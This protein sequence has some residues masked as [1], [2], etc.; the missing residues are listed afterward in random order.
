MAHPVVPGLY[1]RPAAFFWPKIST[2]VR[3]LK[4]RA[5]L[6]TLRGRFRLLRWISPAMAVAAA[7]RLFLTP[8]RHAFSEAEFAALEE[9][10]LFP[11]PMVTGRLVGWRWGSARRPTVVLVHGWGGRGAQLRHFVEPLLARGYAVVAYD[12]P[13]HGMTGGGESSIVHFAAALEAVLA[14][15]GR[16][17]ALLGHSMGAA[18]LAH[19]LARRPDVARAVLVAPPASLLRASQAFAGLAGLPEALRKRMQ[20][21]IQHRFG[22]PWSEFEA[23][24]RVG[25]QPLLVIHDAGDRDVPVDEGRRYAKAWPAARMMVTQG[26]GHHRLLADPAVVAAAVDFIAGEPA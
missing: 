5:A 18:A 1:R 20:A 23:E 8:P 22:V 19:V 7:A 6:A 15:L 17:H 12:A 25:A 9:A 11:V 10:S 14:R 16:V 3:S 26:L 21:R 13:G 2:T 24:A 4:G